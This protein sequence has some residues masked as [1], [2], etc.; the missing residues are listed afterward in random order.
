MCFIHNNGK[1]NLGKFDPRSDNSIFLGA[2]SS[3]TSRVFNKKM[4]SSKKFVHVVFDDINPRMKEI[5]IGNDETTSFNQSKIILKVIAET[6][7]E[8]LATTKVESTTPVDKTNIPIE[9]RHH[10]SYP[11]NFIL[12]K[13]DDKTQ[14][15]S[16]L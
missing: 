9:W 5:E 7:T 16:S 2:L 4:L 8:D 14:T 6:N 13:P 12:G 15:K 3:K 11:K 10:T 1:S